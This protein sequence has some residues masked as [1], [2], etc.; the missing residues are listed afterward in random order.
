MKINKLF[1][2]SGI[3]MLSFGLASCS[4]DDDYTA[5][6]E[7]GSVE[8]TF[9]NEENVVLGINETEFTVT[10]TRT[11]ASSAIT[12]P[13]QVVTAPPSTKVPESVSFA[14]GET[15][16]DITV[17]VGDGIEPFTKYF[18]VLAIPEEYA[19]NTYKAEPDTYAR[20][21]VTVLREDYKTWA[22][23]TFAPGAFYNPYEIEIQYSELKDLY[24]L[25]D[26][27]DVGYPWF[28]KWDG[29][30]DDDQTFYIAD[31]NG[32][33]IETFFSGLVHPT[34]GNVT[35]NILTK[36]DA[37][38]LGYYEFEE[39]PEFVFGCEYTVSAGSF[40]AKTVEIYDIVKK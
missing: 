3:A 25:P 23:A 29:T 17:T 24:R 32:N 22:T 12:V 34:Y 15:E 2:M 5:G 16:K 9:D 39:G 27:F 28:F 18:L 33:A 37:G 20:Y 13:I 6:P 14:A 21:N 40:G 30:S 35:A 36:E 19:A 4:D 11:D 1:L 7:V 38:Y 10:L 8:V 26:L 31:E